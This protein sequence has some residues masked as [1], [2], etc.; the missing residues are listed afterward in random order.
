MVD[1]GV[2]PVSQM[3][4]DYVPD[5]GNTIIGFADST[6]FVLDTNAATNEEEDNYNEEDDD[7]CETEKEVIKIKKRSAA[8]I[9][10]R[11]QI[12]I[13]SGAILDE[14]IL[15]DPNDGLPHAGKWP[16]EEERFAYLLINK[17][18]NGMLDDCEEGT[19]LRSYLAKT[20]R[21]A[22]MRVSKK[23]A[24]KCV[25][26]KAYEHHGDHIPSSQGPTLS[27]SLRLTGF[28]HPT[29]FSHNA[30]A[31][32]SP[33]YSLRER[34]SYDEYDCD[35]SSSTSGEDLNDASS[36]SSSDSGAS[37]S[38]CPTHRQ[39]RRNLGMGDAP[40]NR[41]SCTHRRSQHAPRQRA[42]DLVAVPDYD[43]AAAT[44]LNHASDEYDEWRQA[45]QY[46]CTADTGL[47][48]GMK[49]THSAAL[50]SIFG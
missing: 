23:F 41:S 16:M 22:P 4:L 26:S 8:Q 35:E 47:N 34:R 44:D 33:K 7:D 17:F 45:L 31:P 11:L 37:D 30:T 36:G 50:L 3:Q 29:G 13:L 27:L 28:N 5:D 32:S 9:S 19:T 6:A 39:K 24:G 46:F 48:S 1:V 14:D 10:E 18:E 2:Q 12:E 43:P 49:Q 42:D 15:W 21:C 25:G 40:S 38:T 20:L